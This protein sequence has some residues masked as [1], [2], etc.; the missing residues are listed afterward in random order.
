MRDS[1]KA[2]T[3]SHISAVVDDDGMRSGELLIV[4]AAAAHRTPARAMVRHPIGVSLKSPS[5]R[6]LRP[7]AA[8]SSR[9]ALPSQ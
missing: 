4:T 2:S 3:A 7:G 8:A 1:S 6:S 5:S 9:S